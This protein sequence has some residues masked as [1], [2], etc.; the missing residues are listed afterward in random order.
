[1]KQP[2]HTTAPAVAIPSTPLE[3]PGSS[4]AVLRGLLLTYIDLVGVQELLALMHPST[5][6]Y[7]VNTP[8]YKD[9]I[10]PSTKIYNVNTPKYRDLIHP[11]YKDL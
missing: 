11:K 9:L 1:M 4:G 10:H 3:Q 2:R 7:N 5:K 6:I 8:K